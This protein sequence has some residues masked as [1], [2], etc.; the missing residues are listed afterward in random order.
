MHVSVCG[1][2]SVAIE[3]E[4]PIHNRTEFT[5]LH[6]VKDFFQG[7]TEDFLFR[8]QVQQVYPKHADAGLYKGIRV[9]EGHAE[10]GHGNSQPASRLAG[11]DVTESVDHQTPQRRQQPAARLGGPAAHGV[12]C[13]VDTALAHRADGGTL[14]IPPRVEARRRSQL[15]HDKYPLAF[16][17]GGAVHL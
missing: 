10:H 14:P 11:H 15:V 7:G 5:G 2:R 17:A 8:L 9:N 12:E 6:A 1:H 16:R 4:R 3:W 13:H